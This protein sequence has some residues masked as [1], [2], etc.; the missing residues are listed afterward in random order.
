MRKWQ[1]IC[2]MSCQCSFKR[3]VIHHGWFHYCW[4]FISQHHVRCFFLSVLCDHRLDI[5]GGCICQALPAMETPT[6]FRPEINPPP[7]RCPPFFKGAVIAPFFY[8]KSHHLCECISINDIPDLSRH[9]PCALKLLQRRPN[10][11]PN[12]QLLQHDPYDGDDRAPGKG[13]CQKTAFYEIKPLG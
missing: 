8:S 4:N 10:W 11:I 7:N 6:R 12:A 2:F 3:K 13:G 5:F 1:A 9:R